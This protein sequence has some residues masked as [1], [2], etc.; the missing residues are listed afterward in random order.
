MTIFA[1]LLTRS[2]GDKRFTGLFQQLQAHGV[3]LKDAPIGNSHSKLVITGP[4][5]KSTARTTTRHTFPN[6]MYTHHLKQPFEA[7]LTWSNT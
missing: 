6:N 7:I 5:H 4:S 3:E 1:A 2:G